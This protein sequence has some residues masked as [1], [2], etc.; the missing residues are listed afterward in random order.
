M[1]WGPITVWLIGLT[2]VDLMLGLRFMPLGRIGFGVRQALASIRTSKG[3][4]DGSASEGLT[5]APAATIGSGNV[6]GV[7]GAIATGGVIWTIAD[8]LNGQMAIPNLIS[9]PLLSGTV[10]RLSPY[11]YNRKGALLQSE[12]GI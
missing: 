9:V 1:V 12:S 8:F 11:R 3:E 5:T 2:G 7:A 4:G 10:F 6:A